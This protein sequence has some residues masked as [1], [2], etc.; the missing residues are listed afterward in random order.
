M[1]GDFAGMRRSLAVVQRGLEQLAARQEQMVQNIARLQAAEQ[2][3][4]EE[5]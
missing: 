3:V 5:R 1:A 4:R 2:D